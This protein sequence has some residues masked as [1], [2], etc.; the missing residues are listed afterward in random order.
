MSPKESSL[1]IPADLAGQPNHDPKLLAL[2]PVPRLGGA[3]PAVPPTWDADQPLL[4]FGE[5]QAFTIRHARAGVIV[6]GELGS[7]KTSGSKTFALNYLDAGFGGLVLCVKPEEASEWVGYAEAAGRSKD[8]IRITTNE[9]EAHPY[10]FDFMAH[11]MTQAGNSTLATVTMIQEVTAVL[12]RNGGGNA[13]NDEFWS[14]NANKL[15]KNTIDLYK[16]AY[17]GGQA[18]RDQ[19]H[20]GP[21]EWLPPYQPTI[22]TILKLITSAATKTEDF[23]SELAT[24]ASLNLKCLRLAQKVAEF[25]AKS[26]SKHSENV[27]TIFNLTN[28]FWKTE[29]A[30]DGLGDSRLRD[31]IVAFAQSTMETLERGEVANLFQRVQRV[32]PRTGKQEWVDT[33]TPEMVDEGKIIIV[34]VPVLVWRQAGQLAGCIWKYVVQRFLERRSDRTRAKLEAVKAEFHTELAAAQR[35]L[36]AAE[37]VSAAER[38][39]P[40]WLTL[41]KAAARQRARLAAID[42]LAYIEA[43]FA[44]KRKRV[45]DSVRQVFF[46]VDEC[47][48]FLTKRDVEY[49][50]TARSGGGCSF[51]MTQTLASLYD[52]VG[53]E[54][55]EAMVSNHATKLCFK[56]NHPGTNQWASETIGSDFRY[57]E[58][59]GESYKNFL[60]PIGSRSDSRKKEKLPLVEP[61][62][63]TLLKPGGPL[64]DCKVSAIMIGPE[65]FG[66]RTTWKCVE[67]DQNIGRLQVDLP[68]EAKRKAKARVKLELGL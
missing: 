35:K 7:G 39:L 11:E 32:N 40:D 59:T 66:P 56:N 44:A 19:G 34:D 25:H 2:E 21:D 49:Q 30:K 54:T 57:V 3:A 16:L 37:A 41:G 28:A 51:F 27:V 58:T 22:L 38:L 8:V 23:G 67:F 18:M 55:T 24:E 12:R 43:K 68:E 60:D 4:K 31:N 15:I 62:E 48:N 61:I 64:N 33:V 46:W 65:R 45:E 6:F 50:S 63:F 52:A 17:H 20:L 36:M 9:D 53:K 26:K 42:E 13:S 47:H 29:W 1:I 14:A 5:D 10:R